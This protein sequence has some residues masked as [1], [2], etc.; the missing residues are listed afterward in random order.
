MKLGMLSA[1]NI[2]KGSDTYCILN[3]KT[4][5]VKEFNLGPCSQSKHSV[6]KSSRNK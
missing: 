4:K 5:T 2:A 1:Y 3:F 6:T